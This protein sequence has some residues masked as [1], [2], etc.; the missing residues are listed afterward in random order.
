[1]TN[2]PKWKLIARLGDANPIDHG[3]YFVYAD[4]TCVYAPEA[5]L[6][7]VEGEDAAN[8]WTVY[9]FSLERCVYD[10][11]NG[12]LSDNKFHPNFA[13][14]FAK[15]ERERKERPQDTTYLSDVARS[16]GIE[17][18]QLIE[19]FTSGSATERAHAYKMVG[20]YHGFDNLDQY[21]L[22]FT[23]RSEV[24]ARYK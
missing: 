3:G 15:P 23:N 20:E 19:L 10:H 2:Q 5:E 14:W 13:A 6:L 4:E 17:T 21:P 7:E 22:I 8:K 16:N 11:V 9:R 12:I 18:E 24:E 1:M